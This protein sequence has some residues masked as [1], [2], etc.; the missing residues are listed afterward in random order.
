MESAD[1][2]AEV[3]EIARYTADLVVAAFSANSE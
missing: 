3:G 1:P 2:S